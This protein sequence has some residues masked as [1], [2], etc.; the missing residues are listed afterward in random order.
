MAL[1]PA[2]VGSHQS[3]GGHFNKVGDEEV[4]INCDGEDESGVVEFDKYGGAVD[5]ESGV[6]AVL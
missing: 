6:I 1:H 3:S 4:Q 5:D 2:S